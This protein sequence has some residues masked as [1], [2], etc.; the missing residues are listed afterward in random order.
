MLNL[1]LPTALFVAALFTLAAS[2]GQAYTHTWKTLFAN[3]L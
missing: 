2:V 3:R 1:S